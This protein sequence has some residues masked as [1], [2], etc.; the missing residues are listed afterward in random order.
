MSSSILPLSQIVATHLT[1][2]LNID[3]NDIQNLCSQID[4]I[5]KDVGNGK[6]T[7]N[8][9]EQILEANVNEYETVIKKIGEAGCI[10]SLYWLWNSAMENKK[11]L[12]AKAV[13]TNGNKIVSNFCKWLL[14]SH[15]TDINDF[16][17]FMLNLQSDS[18]GIPL[19]GKL[20]DFDC[21]QKAW[22][23]NIDK[24]KKIIDLCILLNYYM[25]IDDR[26]NEWIATSENINPEFLRSIL[27]Q[28][29]ERR[30]SRSLLS[31]NKKVLK[32]LDG[33]LPRT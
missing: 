11:K 32:I 9:F 21:I 6:L 5:M 27:E 17:I 31:T 10:E 1:T 4:D 18:V 3:P 26:L 30:V 12:I 13:K 23:I 28:D 25:P 2:R 14:K 7:L 29:K 8:A 16:V 33:K 22:E 19:Y 15:N 24:R 20:Y